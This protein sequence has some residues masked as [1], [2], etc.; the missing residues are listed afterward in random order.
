MPD[1]AIKYAKEVPT[2]TAAPSF[3]DGIYMGPS[4]EFPATPSAAP[5]QT[6]KF[7]REDT[8]THGE[9]ELNDGFRTPS[10]APP[11][12]VEPYDPD[13]SA[14]QKQAYADYMGD[15]LPAPYPSGSMTLEMKPQTAAPVAPSLNSDEAFE[16]WW[17]DY[18]KNDFGKAWAF[19]AWSS[20]LIY[21]AVESAKLP[22]QSL[23]SFLDTMQPIPLPEGQDAVS[24]IRAL[25]EAED[26]DTPAPSLAEEKN[27]E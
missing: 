13:W 4:D 21:A 7:Q 14:E 20:A 16:V 8:S 18:R 12:T 25:R 11:Q 22:A 26:P 23:D 1:K 5:P 24:A 6:P 15:N 9:N 2:Q 3:K 17:R 19:D 27:D 10:A